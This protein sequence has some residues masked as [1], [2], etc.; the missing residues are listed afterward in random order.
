MFSYWLVFKQDEPVQPSL[1]I[2]YFGGNDATNPHPTG[3]GAHVPLPEYVENMRKM[4]AHIKVSKHLILCC[5]C[6]RISSYVG[7]CDIWSHMV[8]KKHTRY[9]S[10]TV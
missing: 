9:I 7:G 8:S 3:L 10:R 5:D 1:V 6:S 2:L 4:I